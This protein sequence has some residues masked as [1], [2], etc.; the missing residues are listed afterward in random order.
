MAVLIRGPT[1][2]RYGAAVAGLTF[3]LQACAG[4]ANGVESDSSSRAD[5]QMDKVV[6]RAGDDPLTG[7]DGYDALQLFRLGN[8]SYEDG[9]FEVSARLYE[10]LLDEFPESR[11]TGEAHYNRGL[12]YERLS[13][14]DDAASAFKHVIQSELSESSRKAAHFRLAFAY[15]K[16]TRRSR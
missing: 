10:R 11:L 7:L 1:E 16:L 2:L 4:S 15:S 14:W 3:F 13:R 9:D 8:E 5:L 12:A 6:V